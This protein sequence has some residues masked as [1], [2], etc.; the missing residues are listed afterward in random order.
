MNPSMRSKRGVVKFR[1]LDFEMDVALCRAALVQRQAEGEIG[2]MEGLAR[3][4]G[5]SRSTVSRFFAGRQTSLTVAFRILDSLK[6]TFEDVFTRRE[7]QDRDGL[8]LHVG[9]REFGGM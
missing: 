6:L 3:A 2:S 7:P 5:R 4:V 9:R 1:E 8:A